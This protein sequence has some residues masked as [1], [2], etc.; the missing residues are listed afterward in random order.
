MTTPSLTARLSA[1]LALLC[2]L[3]L[4]TAVRAEE[5]APPAERWGL[6]LSAGGGVFGESPVDLEANHGYLLSAHALVTTPFGLE[7]GL[8]LQQG[9]T[10]EEAASYSA[11]ETEAHV[12]PIGSFRSLGTEVRY[13]FARDQVLSPWLGARAS[14]GKSWALDDDAAP[15][16]PIRYSS[17]DPS[18]ALGLGVDLRVYKNLGLVLSSYW[19]HCDM[20]Q[21]AP[22]T[23]Y[24]CRGDLG[25]QS[26]QLSPRI[27]F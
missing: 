24:E 5:P 4:P 18:F 26:F 25:L 22:Y 6:F 17:I 1:P 13:R 11:G 7:F 2:S 8:V 9:A 15:L 3:L 10:S 27:R 14:F 21:S 12:R 20:I 16:R 23:G 19:Q